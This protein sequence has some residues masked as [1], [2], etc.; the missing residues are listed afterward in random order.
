MIKVNVGTFAQHEKDYKQM[1]ETWKPFVLQSFAEDEFIPEHTEYL[2]SYVDSRSTDKRRKFAF[3][4]Y[5]PQPR[6]L[7]ELDAI[8]ATTLKMEIA[9]EFAEESPAAPVVVGLIERC[10]EDVFESELESKWWESYRDIQINQEK[11]YLEIK[12]VDA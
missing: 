8:L 9:T 1:C 3:K 10:K 2:D 12:I 4:C 11:T 7:R 5:I 6:P